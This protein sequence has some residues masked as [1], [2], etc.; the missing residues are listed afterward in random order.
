M[1]TFFVNT[2]NRQQVFHPELL[3]IQLE[4]NRLLSLSCPLQRWA[5]AEQG[6]QHCAHEMGRLIDT[7]S[8]LT[9][10]FK[11]VIYVDLLEFPVY[12]SINDRLAAQPRRLPCAVALRKLISCHICAT[13]CSALYDQGRPPV[14]VVIVFEQDVKNTQ[15]I[16]NAHNE[17]CGQYLWDFI[18]LPSYDVLNE[19]FA[20][21][22]AQFL[23]DYGTL[24]PLLARPAKFRELLYEQLV[25]LIRSP[26]L[27]QS[28]DGPNYL[29]ENFTKKLAGM[30]AIE[31]AMLPPA[32][33]LREWL[34]DVI[35]D[36]GQPL[37]TELELADEEPIR[38]PTN[39]ILVTDTHAERSTLH[40]RTKRT[41]DLSV[42]LLQCIKGTHLDLPL[43]GY[44]NVSELNVEM[45][46]LRLRR[47]SALYRHEHEVVRHLRDYEDSNIIPHLH[48]LEYEKFGLDEYG[49]PQI[50]YS[51]RKVQFDESTADVQ[52]LQQD[53][54]EMVASRACVRPLLNESEFGYKPFVESY[55][56]KTDAAKP[57]A[58]CQIDE[59]TSSEQVRK[60]I[61]PYST[62]HRTFFSA[63]ERHLLRTL[64]RY[65]IHAS[66]M[67]PRRKQDVPWSVNPQRGDLPNF[68]TQCSAPEENTQSPTNAAA[69]TKS[70][71]MYIEEAE[72]LAENAY[73]NM[74]KDFFSAG[75]A[76]LVAKTDI[77]SHCDTLIN[78]VNQIRK[79]LARIHI[80]FFI[81][82]GIIVGCYLP[83]YFIQHREILDADIFPLSALV[84]GL[85]MAVPLVLL[86]LI[87]LYLRH[88]QR[89]KFA[90]AWST[91]LADA[92]AAMAENKNAVRLY[93][94]YLTFYIPALRWTHEYR[95]HVEYVADHTRIARGKMEHHEEKMRRYMES[96]G[97]VLEDLEKD[98]D[99]PYLT[100]EEHNEIISAKD[101]PLDYAHA[102]C[103]S[104]QNIAFYSII[105]ER[106][107]E[108][109]YHR[110][111]G[112]MADV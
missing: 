92:S 22:A 87:F 49:E 33:Q 67:L 99:L 4:T 50:E 54:E 83:Y 80:A 93:E 100:P 20:A 111:S 16:E 43:D 66:A 76:L 62:E 1:H 103:S 42:L 81:L 34:L 9:N 29:I 68:A 2:T 30:L 98:Y 104:R 35:P 78:A 75:A 41:V 8:E 89:K 107:L 40:H 97:N 90:V 63:L 51:V 31:H 108:A 82:L 84:A 32:E 106:D 58:P 72:K 23:E 19:R 69:E 46:A 56:P 47:K 71:P 15:Y 37:S 55:K 36:V 13:L 7:Y 95:E 112:R 44:G 12:R 48:S 86:T 38:I 18:G 64:P 17:L 105:E 21:F 25:G 27:P 6:Y 3:D 109:L 45:F 85:S 5:D 79:S 14:D 53:R 60:L 10:D 24:E 74:Q 28:E 73:G 110:N 70:E 94:Q 96:I 59:H 91:F 26:L 57:D 61:T 39:A 102:F 101:R 65:A 11:L 52:A 77:K 88:K